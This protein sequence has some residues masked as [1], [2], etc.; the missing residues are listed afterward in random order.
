MNNG[1]LVIPDFETGSQFINR[2]P[3]ANPPAAEQQF[4][5]FL[6]ALLEQPP[7]AEDMFDLLEQARVPL[8][9]TEEDMAAR[10]HNKPLPL[11]ALEEAGFQRVIEI[12][13][14]M[15]RAYAT[16][17]EQE[18]VEADSAEYTA[19]IATILHR[20]IYYSGMVILE[21][22]RA[23]RELPPG[24][25]LDLH[26]YYASAEEWGVA[27]VPVVDALDT[28]QQTTH[29]TAA[30]VTLL[31]IDVASPY[32]QSM[33]DLNLIRRWAG[34]WAPLVAL[35]PLQLEGDIPGFV[36]ELMRDAGMHLTPSSEELPLDTRRLE[37]TRLGVQINQ[38]LGQ[39]RQRIPPSQLNLG[40]ETGAHV[41]KLLNQLLR[42]WTQ[43]A[44][45][46][47]FRRFP[48]GGRARVAIGFEAM[49]FFISGREFV[50]PGAAEV[51]SREQ[52]NQ[53]FTFRHMVEPA[54]KLTID[55]PKID[56]P[57]DHWEVINQSAS[58]FRLG[59][60]S[61]GQKMAHGQLLALCPP[62]GEQFILAQSCWLMQEQEG[63]L[64]M[65]VAILPGVPTAIGIRPSVLQRG[66]SNHYVR[67]FLISAVPAI[68][69]ESSLVLPVGVYHASQLLDVA[70][71]TLWQV[72]MKSLLQRGVDFERISFE[73]V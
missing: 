6:G 20:C 70:S 4:M 14:L 41:S 34:M 32:S 27:T 31:L 68:G 13:R 71:E 62:D 59:R 44:V 61:V 25:W 65:G 9:F 23:R 16:C 40:E 58:G 15:A 17:A 8:N 7:D 1:K 11:P 57:C 54:Q 50:Q 36:I 45:P 46:R 47:K 33:R 42:P 30:Y 72:K 67:A 69:E 38:I 18:E 66:C 12:W 56:Y 60:S 39:L 26:G 53:L 24:L 48:S 2:I 5:H 63:G 51:Y 52:Y 37:T 21:H 49:H 10:Y 29:C 28:H 19:Y 55:Q 73:R 3:L 64:L 35:A 22:F 43:S